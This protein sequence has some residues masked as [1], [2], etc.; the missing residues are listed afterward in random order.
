GTSV[1]DGVTIDNHLTTLP[2]KKGLS[3]SAAVCVLVVR[4]LCLTYG[5]KLT[6]PQVM[7]LAHLG[8]A[9]AGSKCGRMDQCCALGGNHVAAMFFDG[10][11]VRI[12]EVCGR[13][14]I[15]LV[16]AD[17]NG[18]KDTIKMLASLNECFPHAQDDA[19]ERVHRYVRDNTK[20][21]WDAVSAIER[22]DAEELGRAM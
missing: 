16:V 19:Q 9:R 8:E 13:C 6:V 10:E 11:D 17:L 2:L 14:G 4:A 3:S 1:V 22:G 21:A 12:Y 7:E 15:F 5:L 20:L 18:S